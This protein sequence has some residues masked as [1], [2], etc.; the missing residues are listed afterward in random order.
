MCCLC[1]FDVNLSK[2][3]FGELFE[4]LGGERSTSRYPCLAESLWQHVFPALEKEGKVKAG[5]VEQG[6][7][8]HVSVYCLFRLVSCFLGNIPRVA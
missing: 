6:T 5:P 3:K 1:F 7:C 8:S 4:E 2:R